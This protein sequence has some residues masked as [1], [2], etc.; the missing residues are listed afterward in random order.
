MLFFLLDFRLCRTH[1]GWRRIVAQ[2]PW[3]RDDARMMAN[4]NISNS[5][6]H[7]LLGKGPHITSLKVSDLTL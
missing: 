2:L 4:Q 3:T 6:V 7:P 1:S 5:R